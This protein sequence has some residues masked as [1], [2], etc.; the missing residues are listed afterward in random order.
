[1]SLFKV[2]LTP[3]F[4]VTGSMFSALLAQDAP[5]HVPDLE[6]GKVGPDNFKISSTVVD[7]NTEVAILADVGSVELQNHK[8]RIM[9]VFKRFRRMKILNLRGLQ[10][11]K[12]D[13]GFSTEANGSGALESLRPASYNLENGQVERTDLADAD[14]FLNPGEGDWMNEK[15]TF[16]NI[17]EGSIIE[18]TYT[19]YSG[20]LLSKACVYRIK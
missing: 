13:I 8:D 12:V 15:F 14:I 6:F 18:Y 11:A 20:I 16:P 5:K 3:I 19:V 2:F 17:K 1:M 9:Q 4:L 10:A 7:S